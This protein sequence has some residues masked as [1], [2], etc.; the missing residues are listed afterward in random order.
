MTDPFSAFLTP[1]TTLVSG[2]AADVPTIIAAAVAIFG[3][4]LLFSIGLRWVKRMLWPSS[5]WG[6]GASAWYAGALVG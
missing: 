3:G 5:L 6:L 2:L 1:I 4:I